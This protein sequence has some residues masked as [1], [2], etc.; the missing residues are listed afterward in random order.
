VS[1]LIIRDA[2][3]VKKVFQSVKQMTPKP[4]HV[5]IFDKVMGSPREAVEFYSSTTQSKEREDLEYA[6]ST[7]P[8]I[9][10]QGST[11]ASMAEKYISV[12]RRNLSEKMFQEKF[13]TEI[14]DLWSF[15]QNEITKAVMETIFGS[16][17][18]KQYPGLVRDF[19]IFDKNIE[20]FTNGKPRF[21]MPHAYKARSELLQNIKK[22]LQAVHAGSDF[23]R[24]GEDDP[25]WD[26]E[27]GSK[28][29]QARD[30]VYARIPSLD[31]DARA[32]EALGMMQGYF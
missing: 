10:F 7:I 30:T 8:R 29:W 6:H 19:W 17:I 16:A 20:N 23:A 31:F 5:Q 18:L 15:F 11:L 24:D 4:F 22:W 1:F 9:Y 2:N 12:L 27:K 26:A 25:D 3:H 28:F 21:L 14:E 13:W 32:S